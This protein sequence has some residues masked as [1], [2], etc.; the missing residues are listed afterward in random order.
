MKL[1]KDPEL[2]KII[3]FILMF[4]KLF[5]CLNVSSLDKG[6]HSRNPFKAPY[7]SATD[8]RIKVL[9]ELGYNHVHS[10]TCALTRSTFVVILLHYVIDIMY[11]PIVGHACT[12]FAYV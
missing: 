2:E 10:N 1:T 12:C 6:K 11:M 7:R 9:A 3:E 4:D 5:D 8:F